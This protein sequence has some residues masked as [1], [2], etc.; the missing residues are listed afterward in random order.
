MT[1]DYKRHGTTTLFAALNVLT[2]E[3]TA[4]NMARHRHQEFLR[5]LNQIERCVPA[6]K[7]IQRV[8]GNC[9]PHR[10][11][12]VRAWLARHPCRTF[13]FIPTASSWLNAADLRRENGPPDRL[14]ILR[15][16]AKLTRLGLKHGVF[17]SAGTLKTAI[18]RFIEQHN[19]R[20]ARPFPWRAD[21]DKIIGAR[22]RG[23]Q[24]LDAIQ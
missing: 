12:T 9:R 7:A 6:D 5:F 19:T 20:E 18:T 22:N 21:P 13:H 15:I 23:F 11:A 10:H 14:L 1:H 3:V 24:G 17:R 8:M 2:G 16:F 4:Q